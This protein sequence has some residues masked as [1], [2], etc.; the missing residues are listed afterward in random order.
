MNR[1]DLLTVPAVMVP[2]IGLGV[3][4]DYAFVM[5]NYS[6]RGCGLTMMYFNQNLRI[7]RNYYMSCANGHCTEYDIRF[8]VPRV[9]LER[10]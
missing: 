6:C 8:K 4:S 9:P 5:S 10:A 3:E 7:V 2:T 1:R